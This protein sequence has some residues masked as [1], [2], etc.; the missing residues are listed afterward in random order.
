M[1]TKVWYVETGDYFGDTVLQGIWGSYDEAFNFY[2]K[3][4][5]TEHIS[6]S[7]EIYEHNLETQDS[8]VVKKWEM[9][10]ES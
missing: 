2:K 6:D 4:V 10:V 3:I 8:R 7:V 9:G 1:G 5:D